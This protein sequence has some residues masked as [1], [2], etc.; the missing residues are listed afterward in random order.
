[1]ASKKQWAAILFVLLLTIQMSLSSGD[2]IAGTLGGMTS[3]FLISYFVVYVYNGRGN[4][5]PT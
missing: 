3:M 5:E 2:G 1:M 4:A